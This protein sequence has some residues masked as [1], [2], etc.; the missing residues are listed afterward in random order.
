M[1]PH[2]AKHPYVLK[3]IGCGHGVLFSDPCVD[4][5]L[6]SLHDQYNRAVKTISKIQGRLKELGEP[7]GGYVPRPIK[8]KMVTKRTQN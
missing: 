1:K 6:A 7:V 8:P 4:C 3:F 5:E 2:D